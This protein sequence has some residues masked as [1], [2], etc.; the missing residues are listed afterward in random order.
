MDVRPLTSGAD[1]SSLIFRG[2]EKLQIEH[3]WVCPVSHYILPAH[4]ETFWLGGINLRDHTKTKT[5]YWRQNWRAGASQPSRSELIFAHVRRVSAHAWLRYALLFI[6]NHFQIFHTLP[7]E[8]LLSI[9]RHALQTS[10]TDRGCSSSQSSWF[11]G[12]N[13]K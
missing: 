2:W 9:R 6:R 4:I 7:R 11:E 13:W 5:S 10:V 1:S 8:I 12:A 3:Y